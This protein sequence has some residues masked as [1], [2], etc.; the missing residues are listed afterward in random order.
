VIKESYKQIIK[1]VK[2]QSRVKGLTHR[3]YTYPAGFSPKFVSSAIENLTK[4]GDVVLD[5]FM[6]GGTSVVEGMRLGRK[7]IGVDLNY[8][9]FFVSKVKTT[10]LKPE[11]K[12]F[13][14][15]WIIQ[16]DKKLKNKIVLDKF[17][18]KALN[19]INYKG[20]G[21]GQIYRLKQILC[22]CSYF[23]K[24]LKKV[25]NK[26]VNNFLK[27][28]ILR[29]MQST[30]HNRRPICEFETFKQ[31]IKSNCLDMLD[32]MNE[33]EINVKL[34]SSKKIL[35][36]SAIYNKCASKSL[37]NK[38]LK[39][40][41]TKLIITSPPYPGINVYYGTWQIHGRRNTSLP[42]LILGMKQPVNRSVLNFQYPKNKDLRI[43]FE[44]MEK[45]FSKLYKASNKKTLLMQLVAFN[46]L[47]GAFDMYLKTMKKCGFEEIKLNG[48]KRIWRTVPNRSW[49]ATH[50]KGELS[51][52]KEVLLLHKA[53]GITR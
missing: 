47:D 19:L 46:K 21:K 10:I 43:Y 38:N 35:R 20:L 49:Q 27:L 1:S 11:Q 39:D 33:L 15:K 44:T 34:N 30:L 2:D 29:S 4:K 12:E 41:K 48:R 28:L 24:N 23:L 13:I 6:G 9:S 18:K 53:N 40:R 25:K 3:F 45:V 31:K 52:S 51:S 50:A 17:T 42:Y 26:K 7:T 37:S 8:I 5:P 22:G 16:F 14:E 32:G 36:S